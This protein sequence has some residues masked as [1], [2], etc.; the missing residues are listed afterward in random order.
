MV[1]KRALVVSR[2]LLPFR[3]TPA[4]SVQNLRAQ[5]PV[6]SERYHMVVTSNIRVKETA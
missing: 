5:N 6:T 4:P 1:Q 3:R 2:Y